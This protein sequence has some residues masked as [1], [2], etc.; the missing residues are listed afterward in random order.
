M[1][2]LDLPRSMGRVV[3]G[4]NS[5]EQ[6]EN[7]YTADINTMPSEFKESQEP[8]IVIQDPVVSQLGEKMIPEEEL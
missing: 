4:Q 6:A 1:A 3:P 7:F 5:K 8:G 2:Y